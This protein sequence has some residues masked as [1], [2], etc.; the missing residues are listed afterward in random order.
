[1]VKVPQQASRSDHHFHNQQKRLGPLLRQECLSPITP[2]TPRGFAPRGLSSALSES[3]SLPVPLAST[4]QCQAP[5]ISAGISITTLIPMPGPE[6]VPVKDPEPDTD[7]PMGDPPNLTDVV[8]AYCEPP[9]PDVSSSHSLPP[10][11][12]NPLAGLDIT[13]FLV[14]QELSDQDA[15]A[16]STPTTVVAAAEVRDQPVATEA[17]PD[18]APDSAPGLFPESVPS[19]SPRNGLARPWRPP[20]KKKGWKR[21]I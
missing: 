9:T 3:N 1:M 19:S 18:P 8:I 10:A 5:P 6:L 16:G 4:G 20:K 14:D 21:S 17:A 7:P 2:G 15:D 13:P 11:E 12:D